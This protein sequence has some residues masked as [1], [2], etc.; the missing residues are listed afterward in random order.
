MKYYS[1]L[2]QMEIINFNLYKC[3]Q[4]EIGPIE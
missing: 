4:Q 3:M 2:K 1:S